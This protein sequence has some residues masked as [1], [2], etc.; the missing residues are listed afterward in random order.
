MIVTITAVCRSE[1]CPSSGVSNIFEREI[2]VEGDT[3]C[4]SCQNI[5]TDITVIES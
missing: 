1:S 5:I 3:F 4:G 2:G